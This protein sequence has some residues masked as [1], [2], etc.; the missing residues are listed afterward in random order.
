MDRSPEVDNLP[1]DTRQITKGC[2]FAHKNGVACWNRAKKMD[3]F[4]AHACTDCLIYLANHKNSILS[5]TDISNVIELR[6]QNV[7]PA[8]SAPFTPQPKKH[9][10][11]ISK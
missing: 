9:P 3:P 2:L 11:S 5:Q 1:C 6:Q 10:D 4:F 7:L 8:P